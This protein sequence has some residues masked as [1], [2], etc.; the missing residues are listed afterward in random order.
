[1]EVIVGARGEGVK[2][3]IVLRI[4][5]KRVIVAVKTSYEK[6]ASLYPQILN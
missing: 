6:W 3:F 5:E 1:V 4:R 2:G